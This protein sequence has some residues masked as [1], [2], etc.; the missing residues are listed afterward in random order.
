[1]PTALPNPEL[2]IGYLTALPGAASPLFVR[3]V[4]RQERRFGAA[5]EINRRAVLPPEAC[6]TPWKSE[7]V[8]W[9]R[10]LCV[11]SRVDDSSA[12]VESAKLFEPPNSPRKIL[13]L[14]PRYQRV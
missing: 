5:G 8:S 7:P 9:T 6:E 14:S 4:S 10:L 2:E 11:L 1:M 3:Q 13:A 12:A